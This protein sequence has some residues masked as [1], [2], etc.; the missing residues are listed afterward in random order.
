MCGRYSIYESMDAYLKQLA[1]D[2]VVINDD[3]ERINRY[4][5]APSSRMEVI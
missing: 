4:H 5:M 2:L 1:P 3:H